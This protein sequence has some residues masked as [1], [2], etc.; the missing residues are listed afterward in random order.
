MFRFPGRQEPRTGDGGALT[1]DDP[2][3]A[4]RAKRLRWLGIDKGTWDRTEGDRS[5]W[6]EYSVDEVGLKC[7]MNDIAAAI[8]LVQLARA[9]CHERAPRRDRGPV[10]VGLGRRAR[11]GDTAPRQA[12]SSS[13]WH[14]YCIK[15]ERRDD[16]SVWLQ[17]RG[18]C[19]GVHYKP[20]HTY[21]CYGN[22]PA[23]ETAERVFPFI[24]SLPMHPGLTEDDV[25][26]VVS[27]ITSFY[28]R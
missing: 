12:G 11:G 1:L 2:E 25:D 4:A 3:L 10:Q 23:L 9:R 19:T 16:L 14:I 5:Y 15:C 26:Q 24:L 20:I 7:Y 28:R 18:I 8:G 22:Q 17:E 27:G 13:S 6:W 21:R